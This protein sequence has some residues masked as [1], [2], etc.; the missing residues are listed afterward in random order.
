[1]DFN[2]CFK[3]GLDK[4]EIITEEK[5]YLFFKKFKKNST[6][7]TCSKAFFF[8]FEEEDFTCINII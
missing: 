1:M 6:I 2:V 7:F 8:F 5:L 4:L 3:K